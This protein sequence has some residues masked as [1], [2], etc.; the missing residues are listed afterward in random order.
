MPALG[1]FLVFTFV[2]EH[3]LQTVSSFLLKRQEKENVLK[4]AIFIFLLF[5]CEAKTPTGSPLRN[6]LEYTGHHC[7]PFFNFPQWAASIHRQFLSF[8]FY[9]GT[10]DWRCCNSF[11]WTAKGL[12]HIY[13]FPFTPKLISH[14]GCHIT[15]SR[16]PCA[17]QLV[18][19]GY[20]FYFT[21]QFSSL[22]Y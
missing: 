9:W 21:I 12:S 17:I 10:A 3:W 1:L 16:V 2:A 8:D 22:F 14:P 7:H 11:K 6:S 20:P 4:N 18:L 15:L 5:F 13:M 19:V